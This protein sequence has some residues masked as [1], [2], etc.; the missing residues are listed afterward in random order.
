VFAVLFVFAPESV[1]KNSLLALG[2]HFHAMLFVALVL[3]FAGRILF[4]GERRPR[5]WF[6]LGLSAGFGLY[7][8]YQLVLTLAI[9]AVALAWRLRG[10][11]LSRAALWGVA[12]FVVGVLPLAWMASNVGAE[13]LDIHGGSLAD[14]GGKKLETLG[15]FVNSFSPFYLLPLGFGLG[16]FVFALWA[17]L[18][19]RGTATRAVAVLVLANL[20][21]FAIAYVAGSFTVGRLIHYFP[22]HRLVPA[23]FFGIVVIALGAAAA[24]RS[25]WPAV[26]SSAFTVV[27]L[28]ALVGQQPIT[29]GIRDALKTDWGV[30]TRTKGYAYAE[31]IGKVQN[32]FAGERADKLATRRDRGEPLPRRRAIDRRD[33]PRARER[34]HSRRSRVPARTRLRLARAPHA[35][36]WSEGRHRGSREVVGRGS[37]RRSADADRSARTLRPGAAQQW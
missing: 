11:L 13:V 21:V 35:R 27:F 7:F 16:A 2:I 10:E 12:G 19:E 32:H 17:L 14:F 22:L 1:Q 20:G 15:Q 4:E 31:Y 37:C 24:R 6:W 34:G 5:T 23:W 9:V 26:R 29:R 36:G 3:L 30:V 8:S 25:A 28:C 33:P 18:R